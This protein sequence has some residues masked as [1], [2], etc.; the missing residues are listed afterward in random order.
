METQ[1]TYNLFERF[2]HW[3]KESVTIKLTSIG[4]L[5]LILL[6]PSSWIARLMEERQSRAVQVMD[7]VAEKWSEQQTLAGPVLIIPYKRVEKIDK[8]NGGVEIREIID[9]AFFLPENLLITGNVNPQVLHRG[10]FDAV[11]YESDLFLNSVFSRPD[12]K[13]LNVTEDKVLWQDA[14]LVFGLTDLRG[15]TDTPALKVG[16]VALNAEPT[17]SQGVWFTGQNNAVSDQNSN[18]TQSSDGIVAKLGWNGVDDFKGDVTLTLPLK[19]SSQLYFVP[20]G[21]T[22]EVK[23]TGLWSNPSFDGEFLP[24]SRSISETD[25]QANWK[26]LHFNRPFSQQ[27]TGDGETLAH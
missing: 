1:N 2:N 19:G 13:S 22:T 14:K 24:S 7:E 11:V 15:I 27:W 3:I 10:I 16:G 18:S 23:L 20:L 12:F 9:K 5:V 25:F 4:F 8:G 6:I 26:I 17:N 21:K